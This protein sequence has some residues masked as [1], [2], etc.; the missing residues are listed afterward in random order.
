MPK[1]NIAKLVQARRK[2]ANPR[3]VRH[4]AET[5]PPTLVEYDPKEDEGKVAE[6]VTKP[7]GWKSKKFRKVQQGG[8]KRRSMRGGA[9]GSWFGWGAPSQPIRRQPAAPVYSYRQGEGMVDISQARGRQRAPAYQSALDAEL[10]QANAMDQGRA[11]N[12]AA[13]R[14]RR[15]PARRL[16]HGPAAAPAA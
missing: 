1:G 11:V 6:L 10:E 5:R 12:P 9:W 4:W 14:R 2:G 8:M 3:Q 16:P 15:A 7:G 13:P